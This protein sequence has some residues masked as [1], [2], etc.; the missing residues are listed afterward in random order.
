MPLIV[1]ELY[2]PYE[3]T[4]EAKVEPVRGGITHYAAPN[5]ATSRTEFVHRI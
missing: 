5:K 3:V 2:V 4:N 1:I